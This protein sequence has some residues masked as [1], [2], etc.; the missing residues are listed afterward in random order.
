MK[1]TFHIKVSKIYFLVALIISMLC[2]V[3]YFSY[4]LFTVTKEKKNAISIVAGTLYYQLTI[5]QEASNELVI[6]ANSN[7][8]FVITLKNTN[9][10]NAR[11]QISYQK[12]TT[13][14]V[15]IGYIA[16]CEYEVMPEEKGVNIEAGQ[17][18][19]YKVMVTNNTNNEVVVSLKVKVGFE[20]N[21][22]YLEENEQVFSEYK[23][24][25]N[26][27]E[28]DDNMIAVTYDGTNW[29]KADINNNWYN[30]KEQ[31]WANAVTVSATTRTKYQTASIGTPIL[32]NDIETMWVWI[33]RYSYAIGS[34]DGE[35]YY[36]KKG[37]YLE[38]SP[39]LSL[40][41]EIDIV[42]VDTN[43]KERGNAKYVT[44]QGIKNWYT[45]DAFTFDDEELSG[46]WVGKF[47]TSSSDPSASYGGGTTTNLDIMIKPNVTSWRYNQL[48]KNFSNAL[49]M[50]DNGNR[51][52]FTDKIDTHIMK[53]SEWGAV[54]YL[55]QS[56][57]GKLGNS[58][59]IG[60]NKEVYP[61][62]SDQFITGC[63]YGEANKDATDY[64]CH[65]TYDINITGTGASTTGTIFGVYDMSGGAWD[66]V[67]G[68]YNNLLGTSFFE[69]MPEGK[70]YNLYTSRIEKEA[71]NGQE[72]LSHAISETS[73]WYNNG[74]FQ[75]SEQYPWILRGG[76]YMERI[77]VYSI[78]E[79]QSANTDRYA[80]RL[81]MTKN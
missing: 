54:V 49:K 81:A 50:N 8:S 40:P 77:G 14:E 3:G 45:P 24:I 62:K 23:D 1:K 43:I 39:T 66:I 73:R 16:D 25:P 4:A 5:D 44:N 13:E 63:S 10:R 17:S 46:I 75:I 69:K 57:Y 6:P 22:L 30:Y 27:P 19:N 58:N 67:M 35:N 61:N 38:E 20:Y 37:C 15:K 12:N 26:A 34:G 80:P 11:Y 53:N 32:M 68:N 29:V 60:T 51:Y 55:S 36:G 7:R 18:K 64:G 72:C 76:Y 52:G 56:Q 59:Y 48:A 65:Y 47:E 33:P 78:A 2:F 42:F 9:T 31:Q 74:P 79:T 41:G 71:C 21:D 70:Y 28:L